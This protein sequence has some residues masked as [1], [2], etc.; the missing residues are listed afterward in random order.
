[1]RVGDGREWVGTDQDRGAASRAARRTDWR[2]WARRK[3][4]PRTG[5]SVAHPVAETRADVL[6]R[7][8]ELPV[9]LWSYG[10]DDAT[11]RH[12]GP[13]AQDFAAAF[14]LG[15]TDR[16]IFLLDATGVCM[17]AI[18]AL[19]E[20]VVALEADVADLKGTPAV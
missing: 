7:L 19:H 8:V 4:R 2:H 13:M 5:M 15:D 20:R 16:Q 11:V 9:Q 17:A 12:L 14:G 3:V 1:M 18:Q 6:E 10:W